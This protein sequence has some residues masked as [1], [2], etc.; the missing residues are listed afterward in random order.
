MSS[1]A[2]TSSHEREITRLEAMLAAERAERLA[3]AAAE[4]SE[5]ERL[6]DLLAKATE[7]SGRAGAHLRNTEAER[8]SV[9]AQM[10][11]MKKVLGMLVDKLQA[12]D[13]LREEIAELRSSVGKTLIGLQR[14]LRD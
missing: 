5:R 6:V 1:N 7:E 4:R 13:R 2:T 12:P 3:Q 8:D 10:I 11:E 14:A 9:M